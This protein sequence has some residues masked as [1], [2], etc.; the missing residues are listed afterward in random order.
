MFITNITGHIQFMA[1]K[2]S[3]YSDFDGTYCPAR[4]SSLKHGSE[5]SFMN[6]YCLRFDNFLKST[7]GDLRL[8][9]TTGRTYGEFGT[10]M[11][12]LKMR[13]YKLPLPDSFIAKNGSDEY[14]KKGS[15]TD[16]YEKGIFPY[17]YCEPNYLKE[18]SINRQT[19]WNGKKLKDFIR[20]LAMRY[21]LTIVEANSENSVSDYGKDSLFSAGKLDAD[22][23]KRLP[24][25]SGKIQEHKTPIAK[26]LIGSR[27]D[28]NLKINLVFPPDYG[29]C[30]ER[31]LIYDNFINEIK[32]YLSN[33]RTEYSMNWETPNKHNHYRNHCNIVPKI[34]NNSLT[35]LYDTKQALQNAIKN[36]DLVIVAGDGSNDFDM[37]NPLEYIEQ[38]D[39][40]KYK[41]QSECK[42]FYDSDMRKKLAHI[43]E[44]IDGH[45][46]TLRKELEKNGLMKQIREMPLYS[47]LVR[48]EKSVLNEIAE[49]FGK[50]GKVIEINNG[51][52]D[53]GIKS[54]IKKQSIASE[55]FKKSMSDKFKKYIFGRKK[56]DYKALIY[57]IAAVLGVAC[58]G[59]IYSN[60]HNKHT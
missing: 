3:V 48:K 8:H 36:N 2:V 38:K 7:E 47:I 16:F 58:A 43:R 12:L 33:N 55:K 22:E 20:D 13:G 24:N 59:I 44:S 6:E 15:N 9:I 5:N 14:L 10:I 26:F 57:S 37:L 40:D 39:W 51:E 29:Y 11:Q 49:T 17:N 21:K 27:N 52:L 1:G 32:K 54:A 60:K 50:L 56:K 35:K 34:N 4:H 25:Q 30:P 23:W 18:D 19:N 41:E 28:G 45:N 53:V 42:Y 31:N 46:E